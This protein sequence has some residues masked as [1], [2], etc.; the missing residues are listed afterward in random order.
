M[1]NNNSLPLPLLTLWFCLVFFFFFY[2]ADEGL[3]LEVGKGLTCAVFVESVNL[4]PD[5]WSF[6]YMRQLTGPRSNISSLSDKYKKITETK[7]RYFPTGTKVLPWF[8][9]GL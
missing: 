5:W 4:R 2:A 6:E 3:F 9:L 8:W 7:K 1:D